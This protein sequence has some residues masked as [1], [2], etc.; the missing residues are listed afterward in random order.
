MSKFKDV[1]RIWQKLHP[2]NIWIVP[3]IIETRYQ[4]Y[5]Y[6]VYAMTSNN[7]LSNK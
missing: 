6:P 7:V 3:I 1:T 4:K 5:N 2:P